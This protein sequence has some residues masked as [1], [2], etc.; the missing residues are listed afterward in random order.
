[1]R[2]TAID[3]AINCFAGFLFV[4]TVVMGAIAFLVVR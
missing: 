4:L 1:M 3:S 2:R